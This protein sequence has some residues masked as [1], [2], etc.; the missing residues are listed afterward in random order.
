M[1]QFNADH[2]GEIQVS[3][4]PAPTDTSN[5]FDLLLTQFQAGGGDIDVIGGDVIWAA[6]FAANDT[7]VQMI[8]SSSH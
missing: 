1:G 5:A 3:F 8:S 7:L 4:R 2:E 6:Q